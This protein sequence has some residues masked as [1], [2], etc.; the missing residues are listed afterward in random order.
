MT[1]EMERLS[2]EWRRTFGVAM[3][4]GFEVTDD[5]APTIRRCIEEGSM[6]ALDE[7]V[8]ERVGDDPKRVY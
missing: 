5:D 3:P 4:Y 7:L 1:D 8:R 2:R 6:H